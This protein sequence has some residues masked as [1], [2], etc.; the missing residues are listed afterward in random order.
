MMA[1]PFWQGRRVF[2]TGHT[3]FKGTWLCMLLSNLGAEIAGYAL[4]PTPEF[5]FFGMIHPGIRINSTEADIRN[6]DLLIEKMHEFQPEIVFH[7][8][9]QPI[10]TESYK[11]PAYTYEVNVMGTVN[12]L[13]AIRCCSSVRSF[14]NVTTD[15]VYQNNE[16]VWGYRELDAL[17]GY[18]PYSNSKS[19]SEL[20]TNAYKRSF[21]TNTAVSTC[22][23]GN[24]I[25]GGDF[26]Q[27]RIIPDCVR[28]AMQGQVIEIRNPHAIRPYQHVLDPLFG[29]LLI[30][31]KQWDAPDVYQ[32]AYNIGPDRSDCAT[33]TALTDLFCKAWSNGLQWKCTVQSEAPHEANLL[34]L[35]CS[36]ARY[37]L[38]WNPV[39]NLSEAVTKTVQWWQAYHAGK[40]IFPVMKEQIEA[41]RAEATYDI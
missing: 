24:V 13:E 8:A 35:D 21:L 2:I 28:S 18:E 10:V 1:H 17:D 25:G 41:Y 27:N 31:H 22:R 16:W 12:V 23:A 15:K 40:P 38:K 14:I 19:C 6:R 33:T 30:A 9:A 3:G 7:L 26:A 37:V 32:G 29:Y 36:K 39:W 5:N 4:P 34:T 11:N 20:V